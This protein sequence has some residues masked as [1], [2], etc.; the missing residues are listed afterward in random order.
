[1]TEFRYP[2]A[3]RT[4]FG[5]LF[6]NWIW[7]PVVALLALLVIL[8]GLIMGLL[9]N[10]SQLLEP[11]RERLQQLDRLQ[12]S[13]RQVE[14]LL[15][16]S[17]ER[18]T[19]QLRAAVTE[20]SRRLADVQRSSDSARPAYAAFKR[21][22]ATL[23]RTGEDD[24]STVILDL[25]ATI[26]GISEA[27]AAEIATSS[28]PFVA[29]YLEQ[30]RYLFA[31]LTLLSFLIFV[32]LASLFWIWARWLK[33]LARLARHLALMEDRYYEPLTDDNITPSL[34]PVFKNYNR[35][36]KHLSRLESEFDDR[37][38]GLR[39]SVQ[40]AMGTILSY[41]Q[42]L[43]R[44]E[45]LAAVGEMAAGLA[46][47]LRNPLAGIRMA[48]AN[49]Y[50]DSN[51][52]DAKER[53]GPALH[54]IDRVIQT[55]NSQLNQARHVP[56]P[57]SQID[58]AKVAEEIREL[59]WYQLPDTIKIRLDIS[60]QLTCLLPET[61]LRQVL[62]NLI[63]NAWQAIGK[64]AG[65]ILVH[66]RSEDGHL[67]ISVADNGPGFPEGLLTTAERRFK[68]TKPDGT[69]LGL[70]M[71]QRYARDQ[72]GTLE[73]TNQPNRGAKVTLRIPCDHAQ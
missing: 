15:E 33:P 35:L 32:T 64:D 28:R 55:L 54:E 71:V 17:G 53:L 12:I 25:P 18:D 65:E 49:L 19:A 1:M 37:E 26:L 56:E 5:R 9:W 13:A 59:M 24:W 50:A 39:D 36:V 66:C 30:R 8:S 51:D 45:R 57:A 10:S 47:E 31:A 41:Q 63:T 73:L 48:L 61:G 70:A 62:L 68:T 4:A 6:K 23:A 21:A 34:R 20:L 14:T 52:R 2:G 72:G 38:H 58:L 22:E 42:S 29:L 69:G 46:H 11:M 44:A 7:W 67:C 3:F 16:S 27:A 60:P 43:A 40:A